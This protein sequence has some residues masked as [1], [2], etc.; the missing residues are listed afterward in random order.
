MTYALLLVFTLLAVGLLARMAW[1]RF[2]LAPAQSS[3]TQ[4][5]GQL[6]DD[7]PPQFRLRTGDTGLPPHAL[8]I[9]T[10]QYFFTPE[11][12]NFYAELVA[13]LAGSSYR[14]FPDV[15]LDQIFQD[16]ASAQA[17]KGDTA[18]L[19]LQTVDFL[20]LELP[21]FRPTLGLILNHQAKDAC[22]PA[23]SDPALIAL[24]FQS[25]RLPL[26]SI[27]ARH[28]LDADELQKVLR[29]YLTPV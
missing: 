24:A 1:P 18:Q 5:L 8:P 7:R 16:N 23:H 9:K 25:A 2:R 21:E 4:P 11:Q 6:E 3:S 27:D 15:G 14:I 10:R 12:G 13:T 28:S 20:I 22:R 19:H 17:V 29:P 26:L